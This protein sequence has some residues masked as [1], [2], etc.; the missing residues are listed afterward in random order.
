MMK[1]IEF[2][3]IDGLKIL[4]CL[5]RLL[6]SA[7]HCAVHFFSMGPWQSV[8]MRIFTTGV[9]HQK[10]TFGV[11]EIFRVMLLFNLLLAWLT[12]EHQ[13]P[14]SLALRQVSSFYGSIAIASATS[15]H[16]M[17]RS[18]LFILVLTVS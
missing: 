15:K 11:A 7:L 16:M 18:T 4:F 14:S 10:D 1:C 3:F 8:E 2:L 5:L 17:G 6:T 9:R 13:I 12:L